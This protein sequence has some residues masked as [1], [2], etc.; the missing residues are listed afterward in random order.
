M[1]C[2]GIKD[3]PRGEDELMCPQSSVDLC[4]GK[5]RCRSSTFCVQPESVCNGFKDCPEGDDER[6]CGKIQKN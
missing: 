6:F 5:L 2:N 4:I 3:C 1:Q